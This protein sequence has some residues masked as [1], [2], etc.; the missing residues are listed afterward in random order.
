MRW[1]L[2]TNVLLDWLVFRDPGVAALAQAIGAG[3]ARVLTSAACREELCRV[4]DYPQIRRYAAEP[5]PVLDEFD[6]WHHVVD[7][8]PGDP[9]L[10]V[11]R[12]PDDQKF[13]E[14]AQAGQ[15]RWLITKDLALLELNAAMIRKAN[16]AIL[17][18]ERAA[19]RLVT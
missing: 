2:D 16:C 19:A 5:R 17:T 7:V 9:V 6:R 18:P 15:A 13:M 14:L 10:P 8:L 1:V 4:L 12:D 11:C 3:A